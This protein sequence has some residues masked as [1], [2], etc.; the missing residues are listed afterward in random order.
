MSFSLGFDEDTNGNGPGLVMNN[1]NGSVVSSDVDPGDAGSANVLAAKP[2]EWLSVWATIEAGGKGTHQVTLY[3]DGN[4]APAGTFDVT[5]VAA[6]ILAALFL[7]GIGAFA[8]RR[9]RALAPGS[10]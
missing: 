10:S 8:V 5:A 9:R 3:T 6:A 2:V 7:L 4:L 1:L